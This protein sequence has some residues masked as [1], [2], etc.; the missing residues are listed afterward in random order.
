MLAPQAPLKCSHN[1]PPIFLHWGH[2]VP[3]SWPYGTLPSGPPE[4]PHSIPLLYFSPVFFCSPSCHPIL[5]SCTPK[6]AHSSTTSH[7]SHPLYVLI[8]SL[9]GVAGGSAL[10]W[11][12]CIHLPPCHLPQMLSLPFFLHVDQ[13]LTSMPT[14]VGCRRRAVLPHIQTAHVRG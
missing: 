13:A 1:V 9:S 8:T 5:L 6:S 14:F 4:L 11:H 7:H 10:P 12:M 2:A 3:L